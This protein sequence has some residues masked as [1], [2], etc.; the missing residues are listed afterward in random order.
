MP[1][2]ILY[3]SATRAE[4]EILKRVRGMELNEQHYRLNGLE[5][6]PLVTG[7]GSMETA[8][9]MTKWFCTHESPGLVINAGIAGSFREDFGIGEVVLPVSDCFADSGIEDGDQFMT[10]PEAG[11]SDADAFPFSA[12]KLVCKNKFTEIVK[13]QLQPVNAV[14]VNMATGS[15]IT[16]Q[17]LISKFNPDIE[18]MEGATFFYICRREEIPFLAVRAISNMVGARDKSKWDIPFALKSLSEKLED[19]L[20][21]LY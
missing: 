16:R 15:E 2:K 19:L 12:G 6:F 20:I 21:T 8:W 9:A 13:R 18:T 17:K 14:T 7:V 4:A 3:V 11:L 1:I 5:I 10:L